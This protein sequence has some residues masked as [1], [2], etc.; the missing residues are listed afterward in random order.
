MIVRRVGLFY[1]WIYNKVLLLLS[2]NNEVS[3]GFVGY[4]SEENYSSFI[5]IE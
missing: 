3:N 2:F 5:V 4:V 1:D